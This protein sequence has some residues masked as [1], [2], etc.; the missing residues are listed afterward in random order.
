MRCKLYQ[1]N[2]V[3]RVLSFSS[4]RWN[5]DSPNPWPAGECVLPPFGSGGNVTLAGEGG[6]GRVQIPTRGH[7]QWYS[8][9]ICTLW[10]GSSRNNANR[11]KSRVKSPP[12]HF[13]QTRRFFLYLCQLEKMTGKLPTPS[14]MRPSDRSEIYAKTHLW[15]LWEEISIE[16]GKMYISF[17]C[18]RTP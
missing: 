6:G 5:W 16:E 13:S 15:N 18:T 10:S 3:G 17:Y 7:T 9:F 2:R 4:S 14:Y 8:L 1:G 11:G 12:I